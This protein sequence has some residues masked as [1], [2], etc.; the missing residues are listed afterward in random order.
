MT[1]LVE[2]S[3]EDKGIA[4]VTLNRPMLLMLYPRNFFIA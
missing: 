3:H 2:I 4:L 1:S